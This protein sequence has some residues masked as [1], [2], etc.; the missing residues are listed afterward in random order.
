MRY[1][2]ARFP[3]GTYFFTVNLADRSSDLLV[4]HVDVLRASVR[5]V[6]IRHPFEIVAWVT[7]PEHLHTVWRLPDGDA[8][9]ATRWMLIK[10]GFS[11]R[12]PSST[13]IGRSRRR[14]REREIWQRRYWE[15]AIRDEDDLARHVDYTHFN[16]VKH[17]RVQRA[18]D[19]PYSSLHRYIARGV[20]PADWATAPDEAASRFGER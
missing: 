7:L 19:W 10:A 20:H 6:R 15:H 16:P 13:D 18:S 8:D 12:L 5:D 17:G 9:F 2:R 4:R 11:R 1:R 14:K 3:G